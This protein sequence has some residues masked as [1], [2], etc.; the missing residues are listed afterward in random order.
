ME[1]DAIFHLSV[2][3]TVLHFIQCST[4]FQKMKR[5]FNKLALFYDFRSKTAAHLRKREMRRS[6]FISVFIDRSTP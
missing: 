4:F 3:G 6:C 5:K 1:A 2:S